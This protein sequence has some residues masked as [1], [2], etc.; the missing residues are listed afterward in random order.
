MLMQW[1]RRRTTFT[2]TSLK[3]DQMYCGYATRHGTNDSTF[4]PATLF[5]VS[6]YFYKIY[7]YLR[8]C[9]SFVIDNIFMETKIFLKISDLLL[10]RGFRT[11]V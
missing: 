5:F 2:F 6:H 3:P 8:S 10:T 9:Q 1:A 11:C 4:F 7:E